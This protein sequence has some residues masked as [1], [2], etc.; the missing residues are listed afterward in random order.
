M[1]SLRNRARIPFG[2]KGK[3]V[4]L[5][6]LAPRSC[7]ERLSPVDSQFAGA[8]SGCWTGR[9]STGANPVFWARFREDKI[10]FAGLSGSGREIIAR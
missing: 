3:N 10:A 9:K 2:C 6:Y 7:W 4:S 5:F 1:G 8:P